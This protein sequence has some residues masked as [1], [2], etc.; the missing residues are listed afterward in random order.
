MADEQSSEHKTRP[1]LRI[2]PCVGGRGGG[3]EGHLQK[4]TILYRVLPRV[5]RNDRWL[6][7]YVTVGVLFSP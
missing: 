1:F 5:W 6:L 4:G 2:R 7:S 3:E